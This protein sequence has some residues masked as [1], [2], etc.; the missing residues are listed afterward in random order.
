MTKTNELSFSGILII[1]LVVSILVS[2]IV[3]GVVKVAGKFAP[4]TKNAER[5]LR[6]GKL[7]EAAVI[8]DKIQD[9]SGEKEIL[10]GKVYLAQSLQQQKKSRWGSYGTDPANWLKDA[11]ADSALACFKRA[12]R[13]D[14]ASAA[15]FYFIGVVSKERGWFDSAEVAFLHAATLDST[16]I[17]TKVALGSLYTL[18][19]EYQEAEAHLKNAYFLSPENPDV[20]KSLAFLY[21]FHRELPE[22]AAVYFAAYLHVSRPGDLDVQRAKTELEELRRR[23]PEIQIPDYAPEE[24]GRQRK[25]VPRN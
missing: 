9:H 23:Y 8:A 6:Y 13:S 22:S 14:P 3:T 5:L 19:G 4:D 20:A 18:R 7:D 17:P 15:A 1:G 25:F 21:R 2:V 12:S 11:D 16:D 10:R 24:S